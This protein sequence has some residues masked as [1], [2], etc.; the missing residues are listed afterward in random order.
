M[1]D[2]DPLERYVEDSDFWLEL[3]HREQ[4]ES[5]SSFL[6]EGEYEPGT[7][8]LADRQTRGRGRG[9]NRWYSPEGGLW[10]SFV[11]PGA[12]LVP[13]QDL[14]VEIMD[15]LRDLLADYDV[16]TKISRPNDLVV[17]EKK[18]AG[19]LIEEDD[20]RYIVGTGINVNNELS[21]LP[22][23][24]KGETTTMRKV[25]GRKIDRRE[26]LKEI[27]SRLESCISVEKST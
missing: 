5:T 27:I 13:P 20:G 22:E 19:V 24:L 4:L 11:V 26:L 8:V 18:I 3:I 7:I 21:A 17:D 16:D 1:A 6:R 12:N 15:L 25:A 9:T 2:R 10:F 14:Y 23:E